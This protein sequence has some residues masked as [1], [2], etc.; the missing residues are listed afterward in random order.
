MRHLAALLSGLAV[1][2]ASAG[3]AAAQDGAGLYEPFP[4]AGDAVLSLGFVGGLRAPGPALARNLTA[5]QLARGVRV[6]ASRLPDDAALPVRA[7]AGVRERAE[8]AGASSSSFAWIAA[9]GFLAAG[10]AGVAALP[11]AKR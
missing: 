9:F 11:P 10:I 8:P 4:D 6:P 2:A 1:C 3:P 5:T 7:A